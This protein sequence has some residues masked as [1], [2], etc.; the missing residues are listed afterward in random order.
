MSRKPNSATSYQELKEQWKQSG[1]W[2][3]WWH[4]AQ[5]L[6]TDST[7][8]SPDVG[9]AYIFPV[10]A[11]AIPCVYSLGVTCRWKQ[12]MGRSD[13]LCRHK[14]NGC[15]WQRNPNSLATFNIG[16]LK[17]LCKVVF[18]FV[19]HISVAKLRSIWIC[20][21]HLKF[22]TIREDVTFLF[23]CLFVLSPEHARSP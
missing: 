6:I 19:T 9:Y 20:S 7:S 1:E 8:L 12:V 2:I 13:E 5:R 11:G 10:V 18:T 21:F 17:C 14:G 16:R 23:I 22:F 4:K 3:S 15:F